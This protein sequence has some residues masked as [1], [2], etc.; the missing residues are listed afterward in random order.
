MP[1]ASNIKLLVLKTNEAMIIVLF[2]LGSKKLEG[3][4][5]RG[6]QH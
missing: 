5:G 2:V 4:D 3:F 6:D 1:N